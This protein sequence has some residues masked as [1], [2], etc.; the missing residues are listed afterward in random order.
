[1]LIRD[2]VLNPPLRSYYY[3]TF[4][5]QFPMNRIHTFSSTRQ[6][7][8][9]T[10]QNARIEVPEI[11]IPDQTTIKSPEHNSATNKKDEHKPIPTSPKILATA[12]N[13]S[14]QQLSSGFDL[15]E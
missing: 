8:S 4:E 13:E 14:Y 11:T 10:Q 1:M 6:P 3:L 5:Q 12:N 15:P 7:R 9:P 2:S